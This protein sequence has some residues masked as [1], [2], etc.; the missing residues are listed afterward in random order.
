TST[1]GTFTVDTESE[2]GLL[3]V[4]LHPNFASNRLLIFYYSAADSI[5][6]TDL[7]RHRVVT[8]PLGTNDQLDMTQETI[9]VRGLRGPANHDGGAIAIGPDGK[10]YVG[11]GDTGCN[12]GLAT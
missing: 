4:L 6:G 5:G 10:L 9:L 7:D 1:A 8:V 12:S 2:K 11:D 3:H